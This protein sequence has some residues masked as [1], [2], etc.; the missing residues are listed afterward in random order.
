MDQSL[1]AI[2][3]SLLNWWTI[4]SEMSAGVDH[5]WLSVVKMIATEKGRP[6]IGELQTAL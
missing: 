4:I 5:V 3:V 1:P 2:L 6:A